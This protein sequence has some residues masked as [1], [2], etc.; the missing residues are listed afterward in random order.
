MKINLHKNATTTPVQ[1][2]FIQ[3][4]T[5]MS[6]SDLALKI[7]VSETT[8]RRWKKRSFIF[9]K[10]HTSEKRI[11]ALTPVQEL[12]VILIRLCLRS[13]LDDLHQIVRAFILPNCSRSSLN[14]CLKKYDISRLTP[15]QHGLPCCLNDDRGSF[16]YYTNVQLPFLPG[17]GT[18]FNIQTL[19]DCSFRWLH[20]DI[21]S[22]FHQHPLHFLKNTIQHF[23]MTALGIVFCDPIVLSD[24][25]SLESNRFH[26][27]CI[28][29]FCSVHNLQSHRQKIFTDTTLEKLTQICRDLRRQDSPFFTTGLKLDTGSGLMDKIY[30]YNTQLCQRALRHK[31]PAQALENHYKNFP[32]SFRQKPK[33]FIWSSSND[34]RRSSPTLW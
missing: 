4:E 15:I 30:T 29:N 21:S 32:G 17:M 25:D 27:Q 11:T 22:S 14:R 23:P 12:M 19:F 33:Q 31:T 5:Q 26:G 16:F 10:P 8:V 34:G 2:A 1:R 6:I 13:G 9:D 28:Q 20:A 7:G 18:P 24:I 3:L